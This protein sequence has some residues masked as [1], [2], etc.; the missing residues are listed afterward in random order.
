MEAI[1]VVS[2]FND[3]EALGTMQQLRDGMKRAILH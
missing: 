2:G 1:I 3:K